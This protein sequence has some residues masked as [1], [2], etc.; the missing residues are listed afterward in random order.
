MSQAEATGQPAHSMQWP[1]L[2]ARSAE[3]MTAPFAPEEDEAFGIPFSIFKT[4]GRHGMPFL[5]DQTTKGRIAMKHRSIKGILAFLLSCLLLLCLAPSAVLAKEPDDYTDWTDTDSLPTS[6][7]YRLTENVIVETSISV[8]GNTLVLDLNGKTVNF[9]TKER[10]GL[11]L[12]SGGSLTIEDN[13]EGPAED[14][15]QTGRQLFAHS[16]QWRHGYAEGRYAGS[17]GGMHICF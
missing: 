8:G 3:Q 6:G 4:L 14:D 17:Y 5:Q 13:S 11:T 2:S 16:S 9:N 15:Q 10:N 12:S 7:T 1:G